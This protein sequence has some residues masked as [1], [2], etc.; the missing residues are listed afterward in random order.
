MALRMDAGVF[1][2]RLAD[3]SALVGV[4][5]RYTQAFFSQIYQQVRFGT[6]Q[7]ARRISVA[8][9]SSCA[10]FQ[11][12]QPSSGACPSDRR[13]LGAS[14]GKGVRLVP[15]LRSVASMDGHLTREKSSYESS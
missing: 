15:F 3:D 6:W 5:R 14:S 12:E 11:L 2:A 4:V 13:G 8:A 7:R 1:T 10:E 9:V